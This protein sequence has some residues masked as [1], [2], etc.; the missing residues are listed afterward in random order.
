MPQ[1]ASKLECVAFALLAWV[2][3]V[4]LQVPDMSYQVVGDKK[5]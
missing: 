2:I 4:L 5:D 1:V 3:L